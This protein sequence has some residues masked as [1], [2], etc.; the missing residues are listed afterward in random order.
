MSPGFV[1]SLLLKVNFK[2]MLAYVLKEKDY[3]NYL[4]VEK[5]CIYKKYAI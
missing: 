3:E 2:I 5:M 1:K 4:A